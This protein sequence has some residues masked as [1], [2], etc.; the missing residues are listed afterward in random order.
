MRD[1]SPGPVRLC[2]VHG[3]TLIELITVIILI[4]ILVSTAIARLPTS[5]SYA[6]ITLR[7]LILSTAHLGQDT[8]LS[9]HDKQ[10]RLLVQQNSGQ[11]LL[12]VQIDGSDLLQL[13][14]QVNGSVVKVGDSGNCAST[15]GYTDL[16]SN[17]L[18]IHYDNMAN[19]HTTVNST[20][21]ATVLDISQ[22]VRVCAQGD[23]NIAL[24]FSA[25]GYLYQGN[26]DA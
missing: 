22:G 14:S 5:S 8:A 15:G 4:G 25:A 7:D 6:T 17:D 2:M 12:T 23:P 3:Y 1:S 20:A 24:C 19:L 13:N 9:H 11:W 10:T 26:C 18:I 16:A 21:G